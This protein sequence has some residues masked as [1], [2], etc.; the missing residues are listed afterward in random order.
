MRVGRFCIRSFKS[1]F[2]DFN[3]SSGVRVFPGRLRIKTFVIALKA[4]EIFASL[5]SNLAK[6]PVS[7]EADII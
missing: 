7:Y 4:S 2:A 1:V 3:L 6:N 5:F